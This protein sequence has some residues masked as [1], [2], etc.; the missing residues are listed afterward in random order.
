MLILTRGRAQ[1]VI[2]GDDVALTV[3]DIKDDRVRIGIDAPRNIVIQRPERF[4][5][6][7]AIPTP[8][9]VQR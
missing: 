4:D 7:D 6:P 1:T 9:P 2:I 8:A 5:P 3:L